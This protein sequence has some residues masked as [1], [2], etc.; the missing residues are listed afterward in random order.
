[1]ECIMTLINQIL[2]PIQIGERII[3]FGI[4]LQLKGFHNVKKSLKAS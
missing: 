1:V 2:D 3:I 4:C